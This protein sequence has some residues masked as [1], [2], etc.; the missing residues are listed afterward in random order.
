MGDSSDTI[1]QL[2]S[3]RLVPPILESGRLKRKLS[4]ASSGDE[5]YEPV[6]EAEGEEG[7]EEGLD[8]GP[9]ESVDDESSIQC[10]EDEKDDD[11]VRDFYC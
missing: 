7:L 5:E 6:P 4:V 9:V 11:E 2:R 1:P 10:D 8:E 3:N